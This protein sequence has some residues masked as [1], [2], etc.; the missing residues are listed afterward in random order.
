M[1]HAIS[2]TKPSIVASERFARAPSIDVFCRGAGI[3]AIAATQQPVNRQKRRI[4]FIDGNEYISA[5]SASIKVTGV[6]RALHS[7]PELPTGILAEPPV[8]RSCAVRHHFDAKRAMVIFAAM[9]SQS[10]ERRLHVNLDRKDGL[11][12]D[13]SGGWLQFPCGPSYGSY[14][15]TKE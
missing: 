7:R 2:R 1:G 10:A 15:E 8:I 6:N 4:R 14:P 9:R 5:A 13:L 12:D 11:T 3:P